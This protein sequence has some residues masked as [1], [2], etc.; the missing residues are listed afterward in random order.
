M[1]WMLTCIFILKV[2]SKPSISLINSLHLK[3]N[4][5]LKLNDL[6]FGGVSTFNKNKGDQKAFALK[7]RS[8]YLKSV[9]IFFK[10]KHLKSV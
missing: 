8:K 2:D 6:F 7:G 3:I 4:L 9:N 1:C 5:I 10:K